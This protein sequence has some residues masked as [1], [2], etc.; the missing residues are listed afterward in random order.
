[1]TEDYSPQSRTEQ[2]IATAMDFL[3]Q[4]VDTLR[5]SRKAPPETAIGV[6]LINLG[7]QTR[8]RSTARQIL[9]DYL[10][11]AAKQISN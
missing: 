2:E 4:A 1:M 3:W 11:A 10:H 7:I 9:I 5:R 8:Q 6:A